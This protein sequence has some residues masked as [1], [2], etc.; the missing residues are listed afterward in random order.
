MAPLKPK[1]IAMFDVD[2]TLTVPR[3]TANEATLDFIRSLRNTC[4]VAIVGGSDYGKICEQLG[5]EFEKEVDY[6]FSEN[7]LVAYKNGNDRETILL[8]VFRRGEV[9]EVSQLCVEVHT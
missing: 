2:R 3:K 8:A 5:P 7:G 6:L 1:T 9:A 4:A